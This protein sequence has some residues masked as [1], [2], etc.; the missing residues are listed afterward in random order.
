MQKRPDADSI[1][2][3][4]LFPGEK[5]ALSPGTTRYQGNMLRPYTTA[6]S[7][8]RAARQRRRMARRYSLR[9]SR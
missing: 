4:L 2:P 1:G 9:R 6:E 3:F 8:M 7:R 5:D